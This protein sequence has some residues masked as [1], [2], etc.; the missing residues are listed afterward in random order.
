MYIY[1]YL[2]MPVG[3]LG[4]CTFRSLSAWSS[5]SAWPAALRRSGPTA[6]APQ[7]QGRIGLRA[8]FRRFDAPAV[9]DINPASRSIYYTA[10]IFTVLVFYI[11]NS[12]KPKTLFF[13]TLDVGLLDIKMGQCPNPTALLQCPTAEC[14]C[15]AQPQGVPN[16]RES[17]TAQFPRLGSTFELPC[18]S[19]K[20]GWFWAY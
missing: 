10:M 15:S 14:P 20:N 3:T 16:P 17:R 5:S 8:P 2:E 18:S 1:T 9:D 6:A 13:P 12:S 19:A 11:I 7:R 4:I